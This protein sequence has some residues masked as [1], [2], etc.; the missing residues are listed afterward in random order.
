MHA[1]RRILCVDATASHAPVIE[2]TQ[3]RANAAEAR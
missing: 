2:I 3:A 1:R